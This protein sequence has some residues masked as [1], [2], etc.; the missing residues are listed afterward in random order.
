MDR[1]SPAAREPAARVRPSR[2]VRLAAR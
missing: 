2:T 1:S